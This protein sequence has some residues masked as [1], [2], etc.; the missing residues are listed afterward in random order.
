MNDKHN[1][2]MTIAVVTV[3]IVLFGLVGGNDYAHE[4]ALENARL[5]G[6]VS[7]CHA[8]QEVRP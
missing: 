8:A 6:V 4:L 5:R 1:I 3:L 7:A 2:P